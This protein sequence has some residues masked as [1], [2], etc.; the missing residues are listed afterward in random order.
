MTFSPLGFRTN[1]FVPL[2]GLAE[3]VVCLCS[4][5]DIHV[6]H[7]NPALVAVGNR[8]RILVSGMQLCQCVK[9]CTAYD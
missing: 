1:A 7:A 3:H 2:Y 4:M 8:E 9:D 6:S 5:P